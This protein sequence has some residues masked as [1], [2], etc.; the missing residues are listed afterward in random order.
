MKLI[1]NTR[2]NKIIGIKFQYKNINIRIA[3]C[4]S[5]FQLEKYRLYF[6]LYIFWKFS[7]KLELQELRYIK[8]NNSYQWFKL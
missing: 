5:W 3:I 2:T 7:P 1:R 8:Q 4:S 6:R